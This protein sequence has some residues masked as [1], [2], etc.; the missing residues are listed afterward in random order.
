[1]SILY[2]DQMEFYEGVLT[3]DR[4]RSLCLFANT[5]ST[6]L[7]HIYVISKMIMIIDTF[8]AYNLD[9]YDGDEVILYNTSAH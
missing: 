7:K 6:P 2:G 1:M 5:A 8:A 3:G 4:V 9:A